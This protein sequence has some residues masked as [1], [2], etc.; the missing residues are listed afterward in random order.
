[1]KT[2]RFTGS[3]VAEMAIP[4]RSLRYGPGREQVWRINLRLTI[5]AKN[6]YAYITPL[7]R[8][9]GIIALFRTSAAATL[10]GLEVPPRR[11][12]HRSRPT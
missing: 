1:M 2:T 12:R 11:A 7:K 9:W 5:R 3:G 8:S 10:Q 4:F 6:E